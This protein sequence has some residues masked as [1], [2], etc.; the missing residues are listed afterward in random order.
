[1]A[2]IDE[3]S[4]IGNYRVIRLLGQGGMGTVYE[5]EHLEL[6]TRYALKTF[7]FDPDSDANHALR[8]K[9]LEEGKL[10][11]RLKH[12]NLT[13][14][15]DL[16]FE[17][18]TQMP[19]FV[20]DLVVYSDGETYTAEDIE[21]GDITEEMVY[22]WFKQ[23][24][25][26]LDYIHGEG[27]VHRDIKPSNLLVDKDLNVVLTDFGISRI[28]GKKI[29]SEVEAT[30]TVVTKTGRGKLVLGTEHYI[31]PEVAAGEEATPKA[32]A[33]S[34]GVMLLRWL[35]GFYYGDNPG[36]VALLSRKKYQWLGVISQLL[37]PAGRRPESYTELVRQVKPAATPAPKPARRRNARTTEIVAGA[38]AAL[39]AIAVLGACG[40]GVWRYVE[41]KNAEHDRQVAALAQQIR[42]REEADRKAKVE[43]EVAKK[44]KEAE[45]RRIAEEKRKAREAKIAEQKRI[46]ESRTKIEKQDASQLAVRETPVTEEKKETPAPEPEKPKEEFVVVKEETPAEEVKDYGP[47]PDKKYAWLKGGNVKL[48]QEVKFQ[49]ANGEILEL[50]PQK[51]GFFYMLNPVS[52]A[53]EFSQHRSSGKSR[54]KVTITRPFW[55]TKYCLTVNAWREYAPNDFQEYKT[56]ESAIGKERPLYKKFNRVQLDAFCE[57]LTAKYKSQIPVGYVF[58]L[59]SEAEWEYA[60]A[61]DETIAKYNVPRKKS[62]EEFVRV[63]G[64]QAK[65]TFAEYRKKVKL[66]QF[67]NWD[68]CGGL[69][70]DGEFRR[71]VCIGG[72]ALPH[73]SGIC[74]MSFQHMQMLDTVERTLNRQITP[75]RI[76]TYADEEKD[77]LHWSGDS[78]RYDEENMLILTRSWLSNREAWGADARLYTH[79]VLGPDL[80]KEKAWR[81]TSVATISPK[82]DKLPQRKYDW[83]PEKVPRKISKPKEIKFKMH[84]GSEIVFCTVPKGR[85]NMSN[86]DGQTKGH[87]QVEITRPFWIS[88]YC[89]SVDQWREYGPYDCEGDARIIEQV[90]PRNKV[91]Q[92]FRQTQY[93][94]FCEFL[95]ER[96]GSQLPPGYVFRLPTEAEFEWAAVANEKGTVQNY[97]GNDMSPDRPYFRREFTVLANK[98]KNVFSKFY[99]EDTGR[100]NEL[101]IGGR[102]KPNAIGVC[103]VNLDWLTLVFLDSFDVPRKADDWKIAPQKYIQ[104]K[105]KEC[106]PIN[107]AG[108]R[109]TRVL[110]RS[111][112]TCRGLV[113]PSWGTGFAHIVVGPDIERPLVDKEFAPYPEKDFSGVYVG[114]LFKVSK[115]SSPGSP[116][117]NTE[118]C[119]NSLLSRDSILKRVLSSAPYI[120]GFQTYKEVSPWIQLEAK[121]AMALTGIVID[122]FENIGR[123]EHL[124]I[125]ISEDEKRWKEIA[126]EDDIVHRYRF[127][128][129]RK[130]IKAKYIRIGRESGVRDDWFSLDKIIIYGKK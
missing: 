6:G 81:T 46:E 116:E 107:F 124:R 31:A 73:V 71:E 59:P 22:K 40:Y 1:M 10:L 42:D 44:A 11:A 54:H 13:H 106:D 121:S 119:Y 90:F 75:Q 34:L 20:M 101:F 63:D 33:Y 25:S 77:P 118:E 103:D 2:E 60:L 64:E 86:I 105:D 70:Q 111:H 52:S 58:R 17:E 65:N 55:M 130:D 102:T 62:W 91:Y 129:Q 88:K 79:I 39:L 125:W 56:I 24:A 98:K 89:I 115:K 67:G 32:D 127:D 53:Y 26:A 85:F 84:C 50:I 112:W 45:E 100:I 41:K 8:K 21:L 36:A 117:I 122:M 68:D 23:L 18:K 76:F 82:I 43:A 66:E 95:T 108:W 80:I 120:P 3:G 61:L 96:Y 109:T 37:A 12:P 113:W 14:V 83:D 47:I 92:R 9:F 114:D 57:F 51:A 16:G 38:A 99:W 87:H 128:F 27:I 28:F 94:K 30:R 35:T 72:N 93:K 15:F 29:K 7:T 5:V 49:L 110:H 123:A 126:S 78:L 48:P 69:T 104:Y 97:F 4:V 19:Y 74:D